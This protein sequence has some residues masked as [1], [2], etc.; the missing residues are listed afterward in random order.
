MTKQTLNDK[1]I[2]F[3]ATDG[4]EQIELTQPW[5]TIKAAG[6]EVVL[7]SP[8]EGK[9]QG[10]NHDAE[11]GCFRAWDGYESSPRSRQKI[12]MDLYCLVVLPIRTLCAC[13]RIP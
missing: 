9:I 2:A 10:M 8:Q 7:V 4:F 13:V 6:A 12:S 5:E 3:L 11:G 1:R